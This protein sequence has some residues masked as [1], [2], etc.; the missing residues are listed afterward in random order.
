VSR[1]TRVEDNI[2]DA[3]RSDL[4][5][6]C[7]AIC[8]R[9]SVVLVEGD[10]VPAWLVAPQVNGPDQLLRAPDG[11]CAALDRST[12]RCSIYEQ[13]PSTCRRFVMGGAYCMDE[14]KNWTGQHRP[15][16]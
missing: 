1:R 9:L 13:R 11:W 4:C 7:A 5:G 16:A 15:A 10:D 8:C 6:R 3:D 14:R 2:R 12:M